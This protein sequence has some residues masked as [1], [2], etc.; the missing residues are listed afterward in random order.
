LLA[1]K[2]VCPHC[3]AKV[4][5]PKNVDEYLCPKCSKPGPWATSEQ[6]AAWETREDARRRYWSALLAFTPT[7]SATQELAQLAPATGLSPNELSDW[8]ARAFISIANTLIGDQI[9]TPEEDHQLSQTGAMLDVTWEQVRDIDSTL[10][11]KA[12]VSAINGGVM[13]EVAEPHLLPKKGEVVHAEVA[14][15]LMKEVA[16]REYQGG[17]RGFSFPIGKTGVRYRTGAVRGRMV[18]VGTSIEVADTGLLVVTN[19]RTVFMGN[20]KTVD[21]PLP[22]LVNLDVF[23]DGIRFHMSNRVNPTMFQLGELSEFVAAAVGKA[24]SNLE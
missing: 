1:E 4:K 10:P 14:A 20:K 16:I 7:Q 15:N 11:V 19:K 6:A 22:K 8:R 13:P 3:G 12:V 5:K 17:S 24:A 21:M 18:Q 9:L 23:E 2:A